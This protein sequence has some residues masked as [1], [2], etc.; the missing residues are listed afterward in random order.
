VLASRLGYRI[1]AQFVRTYFGRVFDKPAAVF[2]EEILKPE[3]QDPAAFADG[4][5]NII[6][7][8]QRV[9]RAYFED[10]SVED[11]APPL[12]AL[13]HIMAHG[14][15]EGKRVGHPELRA[16]FTRE[17]L[18]ASRWYKQR[19][20][21]K[22][23]RDVALWQRHVRTLTEFLAL[24]GHR[25]EAARLDIA[26]RLERAKQEL[27]RVKSRAYLSELQGTIG[28]DPIHRRRREVARLGES[29][30]PRP[31]DGETLFVVR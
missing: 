25:E 31:G 22:Q 11:A 27:E 18:L 2:P 26:G 30:D 10:G 6:E 9:A 13:L 28:A 1:T 20:A 8:Q 16:L 17:A 3:V 23:G 24:P 12:R 5:R 15:W 19:L 21:V 4:V 29:S 7:T 14:E